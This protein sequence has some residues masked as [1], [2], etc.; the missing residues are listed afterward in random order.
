MW[1][2]FYTWLVGVPVTLGYA[3]TIDSSMTFGD[4]ID[5]SLT[6]ISLFGLF[7]F[8]YN[9]RIFF[10][11]FWRYFFVANVLRDLIYTFNLYLEIKHTLPSE[12]ILPFGVIV[13]ILILGV[14][15]IVALYLYGYRRKLIWH[16]NA[17]DDLNV[18]SWHKADAR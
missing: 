6:A 16:P 10:E 9:R 14:P 17:H 13:V 2:K 12:D 11:H 15:W 8:S 7:A 1:W 18:R 5:I 3:L 4:Y